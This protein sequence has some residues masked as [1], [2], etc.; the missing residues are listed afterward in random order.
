MFSKRIPERH[1]LFAC[2]P[3]FQILSLIVAYTHHKTKTK[4]KNKNKNKNKKQNNIPLQYDANYTI[5]YFN[6]KS[7]NKTILIHGIHEHIHSMA[8][9]LKTLYKVKKQNNCFNQI[10]LKWKEIW[11]KRNLCRIYDTD[12]KCS[13][14]LPLLTFKLRGVVSKSI[15]NILFLSSFS[16]CIYTKV[17]VSTLSMNLCLSYHVSWTVMYAWLH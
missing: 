5:I 8:L 11:L 7:T 2:A 16:G 14:F 15:A 3:K 6:L 10:F 1:H 4:Q 9:R 17:S 13:C 12:L